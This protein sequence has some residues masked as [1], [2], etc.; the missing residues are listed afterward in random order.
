MAVMLLSISSRFIG[1]FSQIGCLRQS[2]DVVGHSVRLHR[3]RC[4]YIV[5][6]NVNF[7]VGNHIPY[8][9]HLHAPE[10]RPVE[11]SVE[12]SG[13]FSTVEEDESV[14]VVAQLSAPNFLKTDLVHIPLQKVG[15]YSQR[16]LVDGD[17]LLVAEDLQRGI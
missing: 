16:V 10:L 7:S 4:K 13:S 8:P 2:E 17:D 12:N 3:L 14:S 11:R 9:C 5:G 6:G 15:L 1:V